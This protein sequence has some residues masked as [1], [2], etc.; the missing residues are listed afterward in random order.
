MTN[1]PDP[2]LILLCPW[3]RSGAPAL[4][5][6][7]LAPLQPYCGL[8]RR[9][10]TPALQLPALAPL[11]PCCAPWRRY[12]APVLKL[13]TLALCSLAMALGAVLVPY[14][15]QVVALALLPLSARGCDG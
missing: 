3:R 5:L 9:S 10:G 14:A 6:P 7:A 8:W 15:F 2:A 12:G 4:Q 11:Q 13:L 1:D